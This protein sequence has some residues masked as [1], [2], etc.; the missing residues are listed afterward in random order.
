MKLSTV[1]GILKRYWAYGIFLA[2]LA[3]RFGGAWRGILAAAIVRTLVFAIPYAIVLHTFSPATLFGW[4]LA[5]SAVF[6]YS[7]WL[8]FRLNRKH[9]H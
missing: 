3:P 5:T 6:L 1:K 9:R 4:P 8:E 7:L 2:P